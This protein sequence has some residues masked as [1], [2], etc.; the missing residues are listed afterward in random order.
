[1]I[2]TSNNK[3]RSAFAQWLRTGR[4]PIRSNPEGL[5][6]KF[7][8]WHDPADGRF[9][10][11]GAGHRYGA[12]GK[13][14]NAVGG[15]NP[16]LH[17]RSSRVVGRSVTRAGA[18]LKEDLPADRRERALRRRPLGLQAKRT[19]GTRL[20]DRPNR[21]TEFV[22][23]VGQ[24]LYGVAE[25]TVD[26]IRHVL[27]TN[28]ATTVR[29]AGRGVA[30]MIDTAI[31]AEDTPAR[32]QVARA[33]N[34]VAHA[35]AR[36][37]GR[38]TG[39]AAGNVVLTVAPGAALSKVAALR[40]LRHARPRPTFKPAEIGWARERSNSTKPWKLY[41]D[42][43]TGARPDLAPTLMRTMP[44]GSKRPVKFDGYEGDYLIDRKMRVVDR[45]RARAQLMRQSQVLAEHGLFE[46]W[47]VPNAIELAN[48]LKL[49][50]KMKVRNIKVRV[51]KP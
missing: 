47:E 1:M 49:F 45:P 24:D 8:P 11:V 32:V 17:G 15:L 38:F 33:A 10:S 26:G 20:E 13:S 35:S 4:P 31:A 30:R 34:R 5:E 43:A 48:A 46:I 40:S 36:D 16:A 41:N 23:G 14:L 22:G 3:H 19:E 37:I 2:D 44:N 25:D 50:K 42:T 7:N 51:V 28:P 29:N 6:L 9:T 27:T 39:S 12:R 21:V 18:S